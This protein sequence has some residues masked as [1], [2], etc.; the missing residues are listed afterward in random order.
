M[1][2]ADGIFYA[3]EAVGVKVAVVKPGEDILTLK[4]V[5]IIINR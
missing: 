2:K 4:H 1:Q 5:Q 3:P